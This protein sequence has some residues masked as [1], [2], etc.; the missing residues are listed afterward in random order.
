M[1]QYSMLENSSKSWKILW[2]TINLEGALEKGEGLSIKGSVWQLSQTC[3]FEEIFWVS[4][5]RYENIE[6]L[7]NA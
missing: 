4:N 6:G 1:Y 5:G 3:Q 7:G 2:N